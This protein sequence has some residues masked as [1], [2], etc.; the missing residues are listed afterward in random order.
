MPNE[1]CLEGIRCPQCGSEE[2]F[3]ID[4]KALAKVFDS[5]TDDFRDVEWSDESYC[6]CLE[7]GHRSTVSQFKVE[8][9]PEAEEDEGDWEPRTDEITRFCFPVIPSPRGAQHARPNEVPGHGVKLEDVELHAWRSEWIDGDYDEG[10]VYWGHTD[11]TS[12]WCCYDRKHGG[13]IYLRVSGA[14]ADWEKILE[15]GDKILKRIWV[16]ER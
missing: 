14:T 9:Q 13:R 1:N 15:Q 16:S 6:K 3:E 5:G 11:G 2:P 10:G 7:C 12:I 4:V 8:N